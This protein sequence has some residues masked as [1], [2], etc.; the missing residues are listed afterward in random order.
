MT[1][2][3]GGVVESDESQEKEISQ[4]LLCERPVGIWGEEKGS[5]QTFLV[6]AHERSAQTLTGLIKAMDSAKQHH[7]Q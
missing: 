3:E 5:G 6:T 2:G 4:G 1:G 7:N